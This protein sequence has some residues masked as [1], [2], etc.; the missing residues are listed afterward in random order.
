MSIALLA[1]SPKD[2]S[3]FNDLKKII[4]IN[5]CKLSF[6]FIPKSFPDKV[7]IEKVVELLDAGKILRFCKSTGNAEYNAYNSKYHDAYNANGSYE[8]VIWFFDIPTLEEEFGVNLKNHR[9]LKR[10]NENICYFTVLASKGWYSVN[11]AASDEDYNFDF[12]E[13]NFK[14][15]IGE[16]D[17]E[18]EVVGKLSSL[19]FDLSPEALFK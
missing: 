3:K 5:C 7:F 18:A 2:S 1:F 8:N 4:L 13:S 15:Y 19:K 11:K 6:L 17:N 9:I 14:K 16:Y 10:L 12:K